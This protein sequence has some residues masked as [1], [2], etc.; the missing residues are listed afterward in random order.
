MGIADFSLGVKRP[1]READQPLP[2]SAEK[3]IH[4]AV[5]PLPISLICDK[6]VTTQNL[7]FLSYWYRINPSADAFL[8]GIVS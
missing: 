4:G 6:S 2:S 5:S 1:W 8:T 7:A 3:R